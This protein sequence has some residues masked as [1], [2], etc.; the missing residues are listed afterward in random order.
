MICL[1]NIKKS[2]RDVLNNSEILNLLADRKVYFLHASSPKTPYLEYQIYDENGEEWAENKE[3][4]TNYYIQIDLFSKTDY[5][6]IELK[7][8]EKMIN[9]GFDRTSGADLYE[10]DTLLYHK[11]MRFSITVD[12]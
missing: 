4:A 3:I 12:N 6:D 1:G 10:E 5:S 11:A 9:A 2:I 8:K 7:I